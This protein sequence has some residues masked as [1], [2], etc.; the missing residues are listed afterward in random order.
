MTTR[1]MTPAALTDSVAPGPKGCFVFGSL[2]EMRRDALRF[3]TDSARQYGDVVRLDLVETVYL[4]SHPDHI[5]RVLQDNHTNYKKG[6]FYDRLKVLVGDGLLTSNGDFWLRQRR[7]ASPAFHKDTL[8]RLQ[9]A[10]VRRTTQM[11][12]AWDES[13]AKTGETFDLAAEMMRLT[14]GI[15][16]DTLFGV[17]LLDDAEEVGEA[18]SDALEI[19]NVR[20]NSLLVL[21]TAIP[22]AQNRR[23]TKA[24][25]VLD[26]VVNDV[27][28]KRRAGA[29]AG[30]EPR[31]D[32]LQMLMDAVD[33][34]TGERMNDKQLRDEV[35][36]LLLAGHETT[37]QALSWTFY[38]LSKHPAVERQ[39]RKEID[40][41]GGRPPSVADLPRLAFTDM[42][43]KEAMRRYPP[44]W[45]IS[46]TAKEDDVI[47]G[48]RVPAGATVLL[49]PYVMHHHPGYW[50][51]PEGFD[52]ERFIEAEHKKR[53]RF[54]YF[55]FAAGPRMCIGWHFAM[56]ELVTCV[57]CIV[58]R[59]RLS[60]TPGFEVVPEPT[61]TLRPADG[62]KMNVKPARTG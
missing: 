11:L 50:E 39:L 29:E 54:A 47:G 32:L 14:L 61:I 40:E 53:P 21:P 33:G 23:L 43:V 31:P 56:M 41:L 35:M 59:Q 44:A 58:Q 4:L 3:L 10:M 51:N 30:A 9:D 42:V 18:A 12:D 38:L 17:D 27:I 15:A 2:S 6:F 8:A 60:L 45:L 20:G 5:Q 13:Y 25:K 48:Y 26:D 55:P 19:L 22:T 52:P 24:V 37:A 57:A 16:G 46:R 1:T 49:S 7:I 28:A 62:V 34:E 36:T